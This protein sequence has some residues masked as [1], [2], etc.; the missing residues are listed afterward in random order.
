MVV[1]SVLHYIKLTSKYSYANIICKS[2][3][4]YAENLETEES[5]SPSIKPERLE[6]NPYFPNRSLRKPYPC[7]IYL[8]LKEY[9]Q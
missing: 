5:L 1:R 6:S 4:V 2:T 9:F 8:T 7:L 3:K